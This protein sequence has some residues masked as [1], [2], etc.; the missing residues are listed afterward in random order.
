[1]KP[2]PIRALLCFVAGAIVISVVPR[3]ASQGTTGKIEGT[4]SQP[5]STMPI[6]GAQIFLAGGANPGITALEAQALLNRRAAEGVA[7]SAD[8]M[9]VA[10]KDHPNFYTTNGIAR[11]I[12]ANPL[13]GV[14]VALVPA[15]QRRQNLDLYKRVISDY[16]GRFSIADI[17]PGEYKLF[18]WEENIERAFEKPAFLARFETRG[19]LL[20]VAAS[21]KLT[22]D[23]SVIPKR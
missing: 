22:L 21:S 8:L 12:A 16:S 11:D 6:A 9:E 14:T 3:F 4:V 15:P 20:S 17:P 7:G 18:A 13:Y 23:P 2:T 1:M 5:G 19:Q 10:Q